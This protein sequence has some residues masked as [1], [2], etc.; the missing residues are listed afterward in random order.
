MKNKTDLAA[1]RTAVMMLAMDQRARDALRQ[2]DLE[3][4]KQVQVIS[5]VLRAGAMTSPN[6][7]RLIAALQDK[8]VKPSRGV[9]E[10]LAQVVRADPQGRAELAFH[11]D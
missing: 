4:E 5:K 9:L 2:M 6:L 3:D 10:E 8:G 1:L 11:T 7:L